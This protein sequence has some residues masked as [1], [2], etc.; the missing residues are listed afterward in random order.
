MIGSLFWH[1]WQKIVENR[2]CATACKS[3]CLFQAI[4]LQV[5]KTFWTAVV[6]D[7]AKYIML[8]VCHG[9]QILSSHLSS[10]PIWVG[11]IPLDCNKLSQPKLK[12]EWKGCTATVHNWFLSVYMSCLI[13]LII[14]QRKTSVAVASSL[15]VILHYKSAKYSELC[16]G[17]QW[18]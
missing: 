2:M 1:F 15:Q 17:L 5:G 7:S 12:A 3:V 11:N 4:A 8:M 9:E 18:Y 13:G 6:I 10:W 14:N 16:F